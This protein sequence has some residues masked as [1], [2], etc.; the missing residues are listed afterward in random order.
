MGVL[1]KPDFASLSETAAPAATTVA[2]NVARLV[3][4]LLSLFVAVL[5]LDVF[6]L[7]GLRLFVRRADP[8]TWRG[9][10]Q[11]YVVH[12]VYGI[13]LAAPYLAN[14]YMLMRAA[15]FFRRRGQGRKT[16]TDAHRPAL[17][18]VL[19]LRGLALRLEGVLFSNRRGRAAGRGQDTAFWDILGKGRRK[20]G[21]WFVC[22]FV[23][24]LTVNVCIRQCCCCEAAVPRA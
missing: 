24:A 8:G 14:V 12:R 18:K 6:T 10:E 15:G 11:P 19:W 20:S 21:V 22:V 4:A 17:R 2:Y 13:A 9:F 1:E 7:K 23:L 3:I 16:R 5:Y